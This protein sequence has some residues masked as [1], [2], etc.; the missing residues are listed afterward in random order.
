MEKKS[1]DYY[2]GILV[3][4]Y[5]VTNDLP[6]LSTDM[7]KTRRVIEVNEDDTK[8][9][10]RL[11]KLW[12]DR[13]IE[14][15]GDPNR[16]ENEFWNPYLEYNFRLAEKYYPHEI[17]CRVPKFGLHLIDDIAD[18]KRG[19]RDS[20]WDCDVCSYK[21]EKDEDIEIEKFDWPGAWCEIIKLKLDIKKV[22]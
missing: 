10:D 17:S 21:I 14:L 5:I 6:T 19:I 2:I 11:E 16:S 12:H 20:L 22:K 9:H 8:E 13:C 18:L 15:R 4:E 3:G 1:K 7:M